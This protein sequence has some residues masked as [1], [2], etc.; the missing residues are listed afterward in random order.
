MAAEAYPLAWPAGW[1]RA[2]RKS[3]A[4]FK[5][6][7]AN[8]RDDLMRELRLM[9]ARYPILSSNVPLRRDGLPYAGQR[10]P[11]D[12]GVAVY[13]MWQGKQMTFACDRWDKV[14]DNVRAIGKTI[15]ALRGVERWGAS[16]MMERAFS[17]FEALPA[18]DGV[19]ALS[20]WQIL[21]LQPGASEM[22]VE[23]AYRAKSKVAHP[24]AGGSRAEW[25]QLRAAYDQA[26]RAATAAA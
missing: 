2:K 19:V 20:C 26:K 22:E 3:Q 12:P 24:D 14:K 4:A 25:D 8:A 6:T 23:R 13:F 17:A 18:P 5:A 16:D 10:E 1:P 15:E 9:G 7:F 21:D 11:E